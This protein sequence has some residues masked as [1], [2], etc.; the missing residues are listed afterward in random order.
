MASKNGSMAPFMKV[1][2]LKTKLKEKARSG[3]LK[4]TYTSAS[5]RQTRR[6]A[7]VFIHTSMAV[8]MKANGLTMCSRARVRKHGSTVQSMQASIKTV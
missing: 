4:E 6:A 3:T 1:T 5:S 2:G 8:A 7:S